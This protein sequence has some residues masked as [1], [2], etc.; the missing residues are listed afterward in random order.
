M[1]T[2]LWPA[3]PFAEW[4]DAASTLHMWTQIVGKVRLALTPWL[5]HSW[6]VA[7][8]LTARGL[9][10]SPIPHGKSLFEMRFDFID[11]HLRILKDD[12]QQK[13]IELRPR[14]V[15]DFYQET[16]QALEELGLGVKIDLLPNEITDPIS[17]DQDQQ[18]RSYDPDYAHR[19]W[20][21]LLQSDRVFK[22]F[23][24]RFIGKCSP[25]HFFWGSFDLAVTRF[26]GRAAPPHPGGV[27]HLPDAVARE[28]YSHE[29]SS[30][31]FWPGNEAMPQAIF[32][33]YAYPA[34][35]GFA[36]AKVEPATWNATLREFVLPYEAVRNSSDPDGLLLSF[37]QSTY[38]SA[39]NLAKWDRQ[40]LDHHGAWPRHPL[41][42]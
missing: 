6:H 1:T 9:T 12:G 26:S 34:P 33:S 8:Y 2:Q 42:T 35:D 5:N 15:A 23:R 21:V 38:E 20:Q 32:Y 11:H 28:A 19:F 37:L 17:F 41:N 27:P 30:A 14:S 25:V 22:D 18:H 4:K 36:E 7:L 40:A 24:T 16:M 31:G 13:K 29:V 10:T 39:A 3:L